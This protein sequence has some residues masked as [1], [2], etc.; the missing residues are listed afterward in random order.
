[1]DYPPNQ[2]P[3][4]LQLDRF[5][6]PQH[7]VMQPPL[8]DP[9]FTDVPKHG[10]NFP[11][12]DNAYGYICG[13]NFKSMD[14]I[15]QRLVM[16]LPDNFRNEAEKLIRPGTPLFLRNMSTNEYFGVFVATS[17]VVYN[18]EPSAF[19]GSLHRFANMSRQAVLPKQCEG[20]DRQADAYELSASAP[21]AAG[22]RARRP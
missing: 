12:K 2:P 13:C 6:Y 7:P 17:N 21:H 1:M 14:E 15:L 22:A 20:G 8:I 11:V 19:A 18:M 4:S 5:G 10:L 9:N 3:H 16:G